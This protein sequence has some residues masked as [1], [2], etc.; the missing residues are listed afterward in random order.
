M[1][2]HGRRADLTTPIPSTTSIPPASFTA[3]DPVIEDL[4]K[5][6]A[7]L[8]DLP[9]DLLSFILALEQRLSEVE[10]LLSEFIE[11]KGTSP[12]SPV[13]PVVSPS[14]PEIAP[15]ANEDV[16]V[17]TYTA[18]LVEAVSTSLCRP[19]RGAGPLRPC[20]EP[21]AT[22]LTTTS[23]KR[24]TSTI[25][26]RSTVTRHM[27]IPIN[28]N[29]TSFAINGTGFTPPAP[30]TKPWSISSSTDDVVKVTQTLSGVT[31]FLSQPESTAESVTPSLKTYAPPETPT[32]YV[33]D[34][35]SEDNVAVYYG[36]TPATELGGLEA[37]CKSPNTDIIILSFL[38]SFFDA[39]GYPSIDFGPGCP[40]Q[41][42]AQ[43]TTAPGLKD[44]SALAPE[45]TACQSMGKKVLLSL[46][47][48][49]STTSFTSD[50]QATQ[51]AT[52]L[53]DLFGAGTGLDAALRPFGPDVTVDGFDID[54]ENHSTDFYDTFAFALYQKINSDSSTKK[55]YLSSSPQCPMPDTSIPTS[56]L[57]LSDFVWVQF[58]NNPSCNLDS[59]GF[60][61]SF[62]AWSRFLM[63]EPN[64][65]RMPRLYIGVAGFEGAGSGNVKGSGL[66]TRVRDARSLYVQNLGG[67]M[68]WDG[69]EGAKNVD[70]YGVDYLK[71]TKEAL[72]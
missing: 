48:Y 4:T 57:R 43:A 50:D 44:C 22:A 52:T 32:P 40:G 1:H 65:R 38:F 15:E 71:F 46:G 53:W 59:P 72:H 70:G 5:I 26:S 47:G 51:F 21:D 58:Y 62:A 9:E 28:L 19:L 11:S 23:T 63:G 69:S 34:A 17:F 29:S 68:V 14:P 64:Y 31:P 61:D 33:F 8:S 10:K 45:I 49:N 25:T 7:G 36:T 16:S 18:T 66:G 20:D 6:Q 12:V 30:W 37:L 39:E 27:P 54:N 56:A 3:A 35:N 41:T 67:V 2:R 13:G 60:R 42:S 55:Y 24:I